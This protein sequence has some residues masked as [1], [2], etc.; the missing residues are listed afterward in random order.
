[1]KETEGNKD[2]DIDTI[3]LDEIYE[4]EAWCY[5]FGI[6]MSDLRRAVDTVGTSALKVKEYLTKENKLSDTRR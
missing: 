6:S 4:V 1:M 3:H 2:R 5:M